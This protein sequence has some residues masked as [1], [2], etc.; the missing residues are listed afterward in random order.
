[1]KPILMI[2]LAVSQ[3]L[4]AGAADKGNPTQADIRTPEGVWKSIA[5]ILG[6]ARLPQTALDAITLKITGTNYEVTVVGEKEPDR[7]TSTLDKST[8]PMR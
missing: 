5:A 8:T 7:G 3:A 1:M 2:V 4:F 6:G